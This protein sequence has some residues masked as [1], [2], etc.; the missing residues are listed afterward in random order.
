MSK[1]D[2]YNCDCTIHGDF[3]VINGDIY[4]MDCA[5]D[6]MENEFVEKRIKDRGWYLQI[7]ADALGI[8]IWEAD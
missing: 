4:C 3:V 7:L 2:C 8:K 1:V 5:Q 6:Y